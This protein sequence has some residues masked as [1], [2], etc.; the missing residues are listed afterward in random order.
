CARSGDI[1]TYYY[2]DYW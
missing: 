2:F 1:G